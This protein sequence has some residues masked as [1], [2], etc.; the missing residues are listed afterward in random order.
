MTGPSP[1][2]A[3]ITPRSAHHVEVIN[4]DFIEATSAFEPFERDIDMVD[5]VYLDGRRK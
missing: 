4:R 2:E 5:K 3:N 1:F